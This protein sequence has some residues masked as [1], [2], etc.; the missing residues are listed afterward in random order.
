[1]AAEFLPLVWLVLSHYRTQI[2][3]R[4]KRGI[5]AL[6]NLIFTQRTLCLYIYRKGKS[7]MWRAP[8]SLRAT[9]FLWPE[10][11]RALCLTKKFV[12]KRGNPLGNDIQELWE[13][14]E[15]WKK[16]WTMREIC[17]AN[18]KENMTWHWTRNSHST[19]LR[20]KV[21]ATLYDPSSYEPGNRAGSI[22]GTNSAVCLYGKFQQCRPGWIQETQPMQIGGT[23]T[24]LS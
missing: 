9:I 14:Y 19:Y 20:W 5:S 6:S 3:R 23:L 18:D 12:S 8:T 17:P 16:K 15:L 24:W 4:F 2:R 7:S 21:R 11:S 10:E 13:N 1:M 22:T